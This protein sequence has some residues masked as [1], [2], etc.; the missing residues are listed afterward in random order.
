MFAIAIYLWNSLKISVV[1]GD[2]PSS[3]DMFNVELT[4][5]SNHKS[6]VQAELRIRSLGVIRI[7]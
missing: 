4:W 5:I 6:W 1:W 7:G 3:F 2:L